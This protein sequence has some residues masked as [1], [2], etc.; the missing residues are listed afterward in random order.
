MQYNSDHFEADG[1][2]RDIYVFDTAIH[3]WQLM[4]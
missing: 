4:M 1:A 3:E 2:L